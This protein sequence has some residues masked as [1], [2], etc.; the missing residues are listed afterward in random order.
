MV[1][2]RWWGMKVGDL[3]SRDVYCAKPGDSL[4][5][6]ASVMKRHNVG[7]VPVCDGDLL[8]GIIT[9]R[10]IVISCVAAGMNP[11]DCEVREFMTSSPVSITPDTEIEEA[12]EI[13]AQEQIRRLPV[14]EDCKLVGILSLGDVAAALP[15]NDAL[16]AQILRRISHPILTLATSA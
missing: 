12:A 14:L 4:S 7:A 13:M 8:V 9:D 2:R 6:I 10:D 5:N 15:K 1:K 3:V 11:K 16:V